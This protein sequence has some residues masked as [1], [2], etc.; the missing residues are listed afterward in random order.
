MKRTDSKRNPAFLFRNFSAGELKALHAA[1]LTMIQYR[2]FR[3]DRRTVLRPC[4][5]G[6]RT[7]SSLGSRWRGARISREDFSA[8]YSGQTANL[9]YVGDSGSPT[10]TTVS[11]WPSHLT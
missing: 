2:S 4:T 5:T 8:N 10:I 9:S 3:Q 11:N 7:T 6:T 1:F